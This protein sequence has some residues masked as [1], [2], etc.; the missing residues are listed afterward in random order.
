MER[1]VCGDEGVDVAV[2]GG[3][4]HL[5]E[6]N[7]ETFKIVGAGGSRPIANRTYIRRSKTVSTLKKSMASTPLV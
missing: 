2:V 5:V 6:M 7:L 1:E 3:D 4:C